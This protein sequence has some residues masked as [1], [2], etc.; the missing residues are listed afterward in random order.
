MEWMSFLFEFAY[1]IRG[2]KPIMTITDANLHLVRASYC[3]SY[4]HKEA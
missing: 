1:G 2:E 4:M 3:G